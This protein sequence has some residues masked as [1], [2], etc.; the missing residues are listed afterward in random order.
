MTAPGRDRTGFFD[1]VTQLRSRWAVVVGGGLLGLV[2]GVATSQAG[3]GLSDGASTPSV[4][5]LILLVAVLSGVVVG[6]LAGLALVH[7]QPR[8]TTADDVRRVTG[9]PVV[10]QLPSSAV[11]A[12]DLEDRVTSR[13]MRTS[14]REAVM[15]T[16]SLAGGVLPTRLVVARTDSAAESTGVDGGL[17]RALVE[18]G[19]VPALVQTDFESRMLVRPSTVDFPGG[20]TFSDGLA[21]DDGLS[22]PDGAGYQRISVPDRVA[23]SRPRTRLSEVENL[24]GVLGDRY[25]V[26]VAQAASNSFPV[27]LRGLAPAADAV[28]LVVRSNRTTVESLLSLYGELLSIGVEPLGVVMTSVAPRHRV[29][30]RRTWVPSDFRQ[31]PTA[32]VVASPVSSATPSSARSGFSI[33][34]LAGSVSTP[35]AAPRKDQQ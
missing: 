6:F 1:L 11:D 7:L 30:L 35:S 31:A 2:V 27:P 14:L 34:D 22:R 18:S 17:A 5:L 21:G 12:D 32:A 3:G 15:N 24:L 10:A 20:A 28:L 4:S 29:L 19:F 25:D 13:R 8:V 26:S 23:S 33:A 16:R 9:L